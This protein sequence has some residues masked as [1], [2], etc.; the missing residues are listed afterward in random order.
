MTRAERKAEQ[1]AVQARIAV[2]VYAKSAAKKWLIAALRARGERVSDYSHKQLTIWSEQLL[3][4]RQDEFIA[5]GRSMA[6]ACGY[7][8]I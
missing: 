4:E 8:P 3:Q 7:L 1:R 6:E 2:R 5:K